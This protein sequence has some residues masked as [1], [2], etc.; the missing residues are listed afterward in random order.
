MSVVLKSA[1]LVI[2][3]VLTVA[4]LGVMYSIMPADVSASFLL[5]G[6]FLFAI[7]TFFSMKIQLKEN[8]VQEEVLLFHCHSEH[9]YYM[10]REMVLVSIML[11]YAVVLT[12]YPLIRGFLHPGF[13]ARPL[14]SEDLIFGPLILLGNGFCGIAFGDLFNHRIIRVPRYAVICLIIVSV[15]AVTKFGLIHLSAFFKVL[16]VITPPIMDGFMMVGDTDLFDKTGSLL[17][18]AHMLIFYAAAVVIKIG[19]LKRLK[20]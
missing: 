7:C 14:R 2:P 6:L 16:S 19:L 12:A 5:S 20:W 11:V 4:F 8:D 15:L 13:F 10:A 17:I 18:L 9:C 3:T 1:V